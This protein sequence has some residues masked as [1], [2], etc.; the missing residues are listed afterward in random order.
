MAV[1]SITGTTSISVGAMS[2]IVGGAKEVHPSA[3]REI[4]KTVQRLKCAIGLSTHTVHSNNAELVN[5]G[6]FSFSRPFTPCLTS[7]IVSFTGRHRCKIVVGACNSSNANLT[8]NVRRACH[9][10]TSK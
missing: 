9:L 1:G 7:G 10:K 2:G 5:L 3:Q 4:R 6:V 8:S